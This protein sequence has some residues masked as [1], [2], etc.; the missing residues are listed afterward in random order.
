MKMAIDGRRNAPTV[1]HAMAQFRLFWDG[2][3]ATLDEQAAGS[4]LDH[5]QIPVPA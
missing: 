4:T 2:R 3:A 5:P 1:Y